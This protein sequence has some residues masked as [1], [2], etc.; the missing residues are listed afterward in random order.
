MHGALLHALGWTGRDLAMLPFVALIGLA[1]MYL[2]LMT[3]RGNP[4]EARPAGA[5]HVAS[6]KDL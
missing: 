1:V 2:L 5:R 3:T 4:N 6:R